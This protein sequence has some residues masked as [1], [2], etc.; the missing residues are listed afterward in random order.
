M[1]RTRKGA[2]QVFFCPCAACHR[3]LHHEAT[4]T[5]AKLL[6]AH[7][8]LLALADEAVPGVLAAASGKS[9]CAGATGDDVFAAAK[10]GQ[11]HSAAWH[12][13]GGEGGGSSSACGQ[14][15]ES[16]KA[17]AEGRLEAAVKV[18]CEAV[19]GIEAGSS[20]ERA[21]LSALACASRLRMLEVATTR[22]GNDDGV[23][24]SVADALEDHKAE[25]A[26]LFL[27]EGVEDHLGY[28]QD[29]GRTEAYRA[30]LSK[31]VKPGQHVLEVGTG[32][33]VLAMLAAGAGAGHV[34]A[35]ER[36]P[37]VARAAR[38]VIS[39]N[40][41]AGTVSVLQAASTTVNVASAA[42]GA[43][44]A[45]SSDEAATIPAL[46]DVFVSELV[47]NQL[48]DEGCGYYVDDAKRRLCK[49]EAT[50]IPAAGAVWGA[51]ISSQSM[52]RRQLPPLSKMGTHYGLKFEPFNSLFPARGVHSQ[53]PPLVV[54][55][56]AVRRANLA[57]RRAHRALVQ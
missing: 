20:Q 37:W 40:G 35:I 16:R 3:T 15:A 18:L 38:A 12:A 5:L 39:A 13:L 47:G 36:V 53:L 50:V 19:S 28:L 2:T 44:A 33:G 34:S 51:V 54:R 48:A 29:V 57:K 42:V 27:F 17:M 30:A 46:A 45:S 55:D 26:P 24:R 4:A 23:A 11:A 1:R 6:S 52:R 41:L 56:A 25:H 10:R 21:V 7:P 22:A 49:P 32:T 8:D 9:A 31:L 14:V 43:A